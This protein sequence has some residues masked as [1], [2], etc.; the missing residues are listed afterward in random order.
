M[1]SRTNLQKIRRQEDALKSIND[2]ND[3][4][5]TFDEDI[6]KV[7][8]KLKRARG[9]D[10]KR[11]DIP[12]IET[13]AGKY[14]KENVLEGFCANTEILCNEDNTGTNEYDN[15]FYNMAVKD[16]M[17]IF[18]ITANSDIKIP[19][20]KLTD[21]K[22]ILFHKLK[23]RK[24]CDVFK[25]TVE[26]LRLVVMN[27]SSSYWSCS[28]KSLTTSTFSPA[29][30]STHLLPPLCSKERANRFSIISRTVLSG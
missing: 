7:H 24:A 14:V 12:F 18:D 11:N 4:M 3:I 6:N 23:L 5:K 2:H 8:S 10:T 16:N 27:H 1:F 28:I 20:M 13:L 15:E 29:P 25:L 26:H 30:N 9:E 22:D 17:I 19:K 21:L